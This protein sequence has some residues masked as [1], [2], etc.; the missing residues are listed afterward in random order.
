VTIGAELRDDLP[1]ERRVAP[2]DRVREA[3]VVVRRRL[4]AI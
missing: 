2:D 3:P 4:V 1:L